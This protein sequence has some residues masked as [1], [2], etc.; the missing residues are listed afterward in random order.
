MLLNY[1]HKY[2]RIYNEKSIKY[3]FV[4]D[5]ETKSGTYSNTIEEIKKAGAEIKTLNTLSIMTSEQKEKSET[6]TSQNYNCV[7]I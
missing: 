6:N 2:Y 7:I 3:I 1:L 4:T 5:Q